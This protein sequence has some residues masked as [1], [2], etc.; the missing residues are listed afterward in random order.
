MKAGP[1][2]SPTIMATALN[3]ASITGL[4][5]RATMIAPPIIGIAI[6]A[7]AVQIDGYSRSSIF[8]TTTGVRRY[9]IWNSRPRAPPVVADRGTWEAIPTAGVRE[10]VSRS[11]VQRTGLQNSRVIQGRPG[12]AVQKSPRGRPRSHWGCD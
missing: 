1:L 11:P 3:I 6:S 12:Q 10:G 5:N 2:A 4:V 7:I 8:R 9:A